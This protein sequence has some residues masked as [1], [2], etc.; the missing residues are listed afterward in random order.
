MRVALKEGDCNKFNFSC[1]RFQNRRYKTKRKQQQPSGGESGGGDHY[2]NMI[3]PSF[4][5]KPLSAL[6]SHKHSSSSSS[7][8]GKPS[9]H[10][11]SHPPHRHYGD[12]DLDS[13]RSRKQST[14]SSSPG[15]LMDPSEY[16]SRQAK[17]SIS[18]WFL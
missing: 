18:Q 8:R 14:T 9:Y 3:D 7:R 10:H 13:H 2:A 16:E 12:D 5:S 17:H 1:S 4:T 6:A 15:D 11:H